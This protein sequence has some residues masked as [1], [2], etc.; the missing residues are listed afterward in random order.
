MKLEYRIDVLLW[1][2]KLFTSTY[3][4]IQNINYGNI[5][6]NGVIVKSNIFLKKGDIITSTKPVNLISKNFSKKSF[7]KKFNS[8]IEIDFYTNSIIIVKDFTET[9]YLDFTLMFTEYMNVKHLIS[10][11]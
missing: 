2:L 10:K 8:M 11:V 4:A 6:V 7:S 5:L 3:E 9:T 1:N